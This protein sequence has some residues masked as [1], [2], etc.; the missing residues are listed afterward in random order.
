MRVA[1]DGLGLAVILE[2]A[3]GVF[4]G[5]VDPLEKRFLLERVGGVGDAFAEEEGGLLGVEA[6]V[7]ESVL[8]CS[9][10]GVV[11]E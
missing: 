7:G 11:A 9:D 3:A 2:Y 1:E 10:E 6:D 4:V 8:L 5:G